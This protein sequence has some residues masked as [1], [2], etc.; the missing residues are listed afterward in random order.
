L[1]PQSQAVEP[2]IAGHTLL[3][4]V[5]LDGAEGVMQLTGDV[6]NDTVVELLEAEQ[7]QRAKTLTGA[8]AE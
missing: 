7:L 6:T 1:I 5:M 8:V 3:V 4:M 2:V